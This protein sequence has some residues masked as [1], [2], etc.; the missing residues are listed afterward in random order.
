MSGNEEIPER[1][2]YPLPE[3]ARLLGVSLT[4]IKRLIGS[5]TLRTADIG[6]R[7]RIPRQALYDLLDAP[8][9]VEEA[10]R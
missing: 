1:L 10:V 7:R 8:E 2:A 5:G 6:G 9:T 4:T 3:A